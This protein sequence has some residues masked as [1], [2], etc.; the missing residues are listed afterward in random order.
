MRAH[1]PASFWRVNAIARENVVVTETSHQLLEVLSFFDRERALPLSLKKHRV[2]QNEASRYVYVFE[3]TRKILKV[4]Y[5]RLPITRTFKRNRKK[6]PV[7]GS[8]K[9][10]AESM[11]KNSFYCTVNIL[12]TFNCRNVK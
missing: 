3:N 2:S 6:V 11:V 10:I 5:S 7:I 1:E 4:K 9:K 12:S 8:S